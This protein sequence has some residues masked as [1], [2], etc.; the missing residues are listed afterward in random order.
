MLG[1]E[2]GRIHSTPTSC[3][4]DI[5]GTHVFNL[6]RNEFTLVR[7]PIF[8]AFRSAD[9]INRAPAKMQ[10]AL[11]QAMQERRVSIDRETLSLPPTHPVF[12]TQN[13][14]ESEG[15]YPLPE[16]QRDRFPPGFRCRYPERDAEL[17]LA[18]RTSDW[19]HPSRSEFRNPFSLWCPPERLA[20]LRKN[21]PPSPSGPLR[22]G[23]RPPT[24]TQDSMLVGAGPRATQGL[25]LAARALAAL[26]D[27]DFVTP[28]RREIP[29]P[30]FWN[31]GSSCPEFELE[32]SGTRDVVNQVPESSRSALNTACWFHRDN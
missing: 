7:G 3:R 32:G 30:R 5:T 21:S 4:R 10:S 26:Q 2:F 15:T 24:R 31:T 9:E 12:A 16:A 11:L 13:P 19:T 22:R 6:Q 14:V 17:D 1:C 8:T 23:S 25:L 20:A 29:R 28:R 27:R 18:R